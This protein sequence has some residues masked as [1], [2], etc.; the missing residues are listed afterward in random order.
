M[1][2][3]KTS[4]CHAPIYFFD[5]ITQVLNAKQYAIDVLST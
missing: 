2:S 3:N 5:G 1:D 4:A